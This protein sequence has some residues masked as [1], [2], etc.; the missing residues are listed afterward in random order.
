MCA[1]YAPPGLAILLCMSVNTFGD[2]TDPV[3]FA[4]CFA[5]VI[6]GA[7]E[8]TRAVKEQP[9]VLPIVEEPEPEE[10]DDFL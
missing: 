5:C 8:L 9:I 1:T 6:W 2:H 10:D 4:A 7:L 3:L